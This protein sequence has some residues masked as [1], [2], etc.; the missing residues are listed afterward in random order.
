M[1]TPSNHAPRTTPPR[2]LPRIDARTWARDLA[3][4]AR[5][6]LA[7]GKEGWIRNLLTAVG[8]GLGVAVLLLASAVPA[9]M[10]ARSDRSHDRDDM[11]F[12]EKLKPTA[13][14]MLIDNT[15]TVY[16]GVDV[17]GRVLDPD[18]DKPPVP[19]G[20]S[21]VPAPGEMTVSPHSPSCWTPP[22]ASCSRSG[23][24]T[25]S[26]APSPRP[27]CSAPPN[28]S[29][30]RAATPSPTHTPNASTRSVAPGAAPR[31]WARS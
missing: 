28:S 21:R 20:L 10:Q 14:T 3:L 31:G 8:V 29:T 11:Y 25:A 5:F 13:S 26:P 16:H 22:R 7:G 23:S 6:T 15:D 2:T 4:G 17:Y 12:G 19:P 1:S 30:T 24:T 18:G 27:D 9:M